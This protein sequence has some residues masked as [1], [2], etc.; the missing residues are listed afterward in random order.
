[1]KVQQEIFYQMSRDEEKIMHLLK[2]NGNMHI[3]GLQQA[4]MLGPAAFS[5]ALLNLE[6]EN[7]LRVYPGRIYG[8][9]NPG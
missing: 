9:A 8:P 7:L 1:M 4:C 2:E 3:E 6:M 5:S